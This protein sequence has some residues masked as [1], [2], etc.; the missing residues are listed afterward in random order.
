MKR[1]SAS[2]GLLVTVGCTLALAP[3]ALSVR[4]EQVSAVR[5]P[6]AIASAATGGPTA[7]APQ[8]FAVYDTP[9][10]GWEHPPQSE[11]TETWGP[12][13]RVLRNV[14]TPT[15]T[16][17]LPAPGRATGAGVVIAPGGGF[18]ALAIDHE[19]IDVARW[20]A[21]HGVA[22]FVLKYRLYPSP[23]D[24]A[25]FEKFF[26]KQLADNLAHLEAPSPGQVEAAADGRA[27]LARVRARAASFG[28]DPNRVGFLGF[29]AGGAIALN[30]AVDAISRPAFVGAIYAVLGPK[31]VVPPDAPPMFAAIADDD[32]LFGDH[33]DSIYEAW[34]AVHRPI[35]L[36]VYGAGGHGFGMRRQGTSSDTWIDAFYAWLQAGG[37]VPR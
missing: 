5:W 36:H 12:H 22:A 7:P 11:L 28:V 15:V 13:T 21:D 16:A 6:D 9:P 25:A 10:A 2:A 33:A 24:H 20:L 26:A 3:L 19:G 29:S 34:H 27:A 32:P 35:E 37:F 31:E 18:V 14:T 23:P 4:R 17:Y 8:T 1:A 30:I